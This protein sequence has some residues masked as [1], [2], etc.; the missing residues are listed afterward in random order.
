VEEAKG[1]PLLSRGPARLAVRSG[2]LAYFHYF[3]L[4]FLLSK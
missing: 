2:C 4:A 3:R 1:P